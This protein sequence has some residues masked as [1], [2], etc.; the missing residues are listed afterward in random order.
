MAL[1]QCAVTVM[2]TR[3]HSKGHVYICVLPGHTIG[4]VHSAKK[5]AGHVTPHTSAREVKHSMVLPTA[6][7]LVQL[8]MPTGMAEGGHT[9]LHPHS[10]PTSTPVSD[11]H[12][13]TSAVGGP[14]GLPNRQDWMCNLMLPRKLFQH[15]RTNGMRTPARSCPFA[16]HW[17]S[18]VHCLTTSRSRTDGLS[19]SLVYVCTRE[20]PHVTQHACRPPGNHTQHTARVTKQHEPVLQKCFCFRSKSTSQRNPTNEP[21]TPGNVDRGLA[22]LRAAAY[23]LNAACFHAN[24]H[25]PP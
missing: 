22:A 24:Q 2:Q 23:T 9:K 19:Q 5:R 10:R 13:V 1:T 8:H 17:C 6:A 3:E 16:A 15:P 20:G 4:S 25:Q 11:I 7:G 12:R 18:S 14:A 21:R